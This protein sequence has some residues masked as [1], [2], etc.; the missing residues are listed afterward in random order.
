MF[1]KFKNISFL[2]VACIINSFICKAQHPTKRLL[3]EYVYQTSVMSGDKVDY[4][5]YFMVDSTE[6]ITYNNRTFYKFNFSSDSTAYS[7]Y[8]NY[9]KVSQHLDFI[10]KDFKEKNPYCDSKPVQTLYSFKNSK[11][12]QICRL[13][14]IGS[15]FNLT[16]NKL[17]PK[18]GYRFKA[19]FSK[20]LIHS[21][22]RV[23]KAFLFKNN[24]YP[25]SIIIDDPFLGNGIIVRAKVYH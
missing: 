23:I 10:A 12:G 19:V 8:V 13:G 3:V 6:S 7:G 18:S 2:L 15:N 20:M 9:H 4:H 16:S 21:E 22:N 24:I 17:N 1:M 5:L 25:A 14:D 11:S